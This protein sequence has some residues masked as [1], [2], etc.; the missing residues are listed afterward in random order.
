MQ[1]KTLII[2]MTLKSPIFSSFFHLNHN[3]AINVCINANELPTAM[4]V[5]RDHGASKSAIEL[6]LQSLHTHRHHIDAIEGSFE[7]FI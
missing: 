3:V 4:T 2:S 1:A 6:L 5:L 7:T